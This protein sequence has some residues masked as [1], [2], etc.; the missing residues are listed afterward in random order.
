LA[1]PFTP[2][3]L[4]TTM[5][6]ATENLIHSR[7]A[8]KLAREKRSIRFEFISVL[9]HELKSPLS[10]VEGYLKLMQERTVGHSMEAYDTMFSR[11]QLRLQGMRKLILDLLDLTR[12]ES[13]Q[14]K[15][16][17]C[18]LDLTEIAREIIENNTP[19]AHRRSITLL[20]TP[21]NPIITTA[22]RSEM[23]IVLN[24]LI[25]NAIKYNRDGGR[26]EVHLSYENQKSFL[27]VSDTGIGMTPEE[28]K[29]LFQDFT[30]IKNSATRN[31][32]G[33]GLGLSIVKKISYLYGGTVNVTSSP[34]EGST[35]TVI[36]PDEAIP[37]D[38][39]T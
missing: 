32:L 27:A 31:I 5:R 11:C 26:V 12:I 36:L 9:A 28:T 24:N 37:N 30:R 16:D 14:K 6:K 25:S 20:L 7:Q 38:A 35:F 4:R 15:R 34:G 39:E 1:K 17:L 8:R 21:D 19:M 22:D 13:G 23:E 18:R 2:G 10:A 29:R 33:S 3:E